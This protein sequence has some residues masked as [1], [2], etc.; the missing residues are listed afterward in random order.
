[1]KLPFNR[2]AVGIH[3]SNFTLEVGLVFVVPVTRQK[4]GRSVNCGPPARPPA[5]PRPPAAP[6]R[7][8]A[9]PAR[10]GA[11]AAGAGGANAPGATAC[12]VVTT[13]F[14]RDHDINPSHVAADARVAPA[15]VNTAPTTGTIRMP[16][17]WRCI[18]TP[19]TSVGDGRTNYP[20]IT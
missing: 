13:A 3:T 6:P 11:F 8:S 16:G 19:P 18:D 15:R 1:M 17:T 10:P 7:P 14:C 2:S 20:S 4:A 9:A 12:T 5:P